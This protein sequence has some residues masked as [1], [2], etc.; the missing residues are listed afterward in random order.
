MDKKAKNRAVVRGIVD[1]NIRSSNNMANEKKEQQFLHK[2]KSVL[3]PACIRI[4]EYNRS[5]TFFTCAM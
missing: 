1:W 3:C 5:A 2:G 4:C